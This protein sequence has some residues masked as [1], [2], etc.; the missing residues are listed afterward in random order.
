MGFYHECNLNWMQARQKHLTASDII[1]LLPRTKTGKPRKIC[2][3]DY[4]K[5]W[6]RKNTKLT[7]SDCRSYGAAARGHILE[8]YAIEMFNQWG[9]AATSFHWD[10]ALISSDEVEGLAFSPDALDVDQTSNRVEINSSECDAK[11]VV[12]VKCYSPERHMQALCTDA[13]E[14]MERW[15]IAVAMACS[16]QIDEGYLVLFNPDMD[17]H[18]SLCVNC[19]TRHDL[20]EEIHVVKLIVDD[21]KEWKSTACLISPCE[22]SP[23][24]L[25][26]ARKEIAKWQNIS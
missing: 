19:Y 5:V 13:Y 17:D 16:S 26:K 24:V 21:Y 22:F 3:A 18:Y 20:A 7:L 9:L 11:T 23:L 15:Q 25:D 10:D 1:D 14:M 6:T 12:E 4:L 2:N 8:P